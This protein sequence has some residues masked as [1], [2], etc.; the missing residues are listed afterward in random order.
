ML[1]MFSIFLSVVAFVFAFS[2][3]NSMLYA[4]SYFVGEALS[5]SSYSGKFGWDHTKHVISI[6]VVTLCNLGCGLGLPPS[7]HLTCLPFF[8]LVSQV[9]NVLDAQ[10]WIHDSMTAVI[11]HFLGIVSMMHEHCS[12]ALEV[13]IIRF[14]LNF[15]ASKVW[16]EL[17]IETH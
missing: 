9:I 17:L 4:L 13:I 12:S 5:S 16:E 1:N 7:V 14:L 2:I 10:P 6:L 15:K 3:L 11:S 8:S